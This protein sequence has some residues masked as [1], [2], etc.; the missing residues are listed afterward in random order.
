M[1][2]KSMETGVE[3]MAS[4]EMAP[5]AL[6]CPGRVPKRRLLSPKIRRWQWRSCRTSS[7]KL[8]NYLA[9]RLRRN[10]NRRRGGVRG[11]PGAHTTPWRGQEGGVPALGVASPWPPFGCPSVFVLCPGKIGGSGFVSSNSENIS[12]VAFLKYKNSRTQGTGT[13]ASH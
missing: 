9:F 4:M 6:P 2:T 11:R 1:A 10:L 7:G 5:G 3:A 13:V 8:P 12:C